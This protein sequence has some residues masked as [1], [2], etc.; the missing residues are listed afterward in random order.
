VV[1]R[2]FFDES[3]YAEHTFM[4]AFALNKAWPMNQ[5]D[6]GQEILT[7]KTY[8]ISDIAFNLSGPAS[9]QIDL[10]FGWKRELNGDNWRKATDLLAQVI[11]GELSSDEALALLKCE[12]R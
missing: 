1:G 7:A 11:D 9:V 8:D 10:Y 3:I 4:I 5:H 2:H 6:S 12:H